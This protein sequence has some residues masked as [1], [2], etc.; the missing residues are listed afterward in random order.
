MNLHELDH[1]ELLA[2][3]AWCH[4]RIPE[5]QECFGAGARVNSEARELLADKEGTLFPMPLTNGREVI[6]VVPAA[7]SEARK[8][9]NDVYFQACSEDCCRQLTQ[10]LRDEL[11]KSL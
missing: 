6:V 1:D 2:R 8:A 11:G 9:G 3:C 10:A 4:R 5:D 7:D